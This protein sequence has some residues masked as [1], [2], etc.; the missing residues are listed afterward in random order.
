MQ[1]DTDD[2]L[3]PEGVLRPSDVALLQASLCDGDDAVAAFR[4]W[5][6]LTDFEGNHDQGQFRML[7]LLH[8]NMSRLKV[9]DPVMPRLQGVHRYAWCDARRRE[10]LAVRAISALQA[11]GIACMA[12]KG[13]ALG[14]AYY[15]DAALRPMQDIDLLIRIEDIQNTLKCLAAEGWQYP[16]C[17]LEGGTWRRKMKLGTDKGLHLKHPDGAEIDLHWYPFHEGMSQRVS[18]RFWKNAVPMQVGQL[19]LLRPCAADLLL[20]VVIHGLR[21]NVVAPLRWAADAT[22]VIRREHDAIDWDELD[23]FAASI[24]VRSRFYFGL[25]LLQQASIID[26]PANVR[27]VTPTWIERFESYAYVIMS[28]RTVLPGDLWLYRGLT[29]GRL[30]AGDNRRWLVPLVLG[31]LARKGWRLVGGGA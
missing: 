31:R 28:R 14:K 16:E 22:M 15:E 24:K 23:Q 8:A 4:R 3:S 25:R 30:L 19:T 11:N 21:C 5:R 6:S 18:D 7:P 2:R 20:H 17:G 9:Q 13:L 10:Y 27:A 12:L 26:L 1:R 29:Y